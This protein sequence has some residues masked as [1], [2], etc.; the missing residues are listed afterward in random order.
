MKKNKRATRHKSKPTEVAVETVREEYKRWH[1]LAA[2]G[3]A[4]FA[5][6]QAYLPAINGA[7]V[8]DDRYL[9]FMHLPQHDAPLR[10]WIAGTRPTL[11]FSFWLNYKINGVV[12]YWYHVTNVLLH[13]ATGLLVFLIARKFLEW[14]GV[15]RWRKE[16]IAAFAAGLFL[17]HPLQTES[18]SYVASRS[19]NLSAL[20]FCGAFA[21]FLYRKRTAISFPRTLLVLILFGAAVTTKEH[22]AVLPVLLLLT[23]YYWNP[24]FSF[25]GIRRNWRLYLPLAV[26]AAAGSVFVWRTLIASDT[27]GFAV[28]GLPWYEYFY[29]QCRV[30][31][32][33]IRM[34]VLPFG[35]NI[36][37][38]YPISKS[39][40]EPGSLAGLI[41]LAALAGA[42]LWFRKRYK[43]ISFGILVFLLLLAPTSSF[44][45]IKDALAERRMYLP[46]IGPLLVLCD[47]AVRWKTSRKA[48]AGAMAAVLVVMGLLTYTRNL[49]WA[50]PI[51]LW[52]DSVAKSPANWRA[53]FQLAHAY[54]ENRRCLDSVKQ[55]EQAAALDSSDPRLF[56]NW[57]QASDCAG[58]PDEALAILN[59]ALA[60]ER[61][62]HVYSVIGMIKAK[63]GKRD[64]A[65]EALATAEKLD[66][67]FAPLYMFRGNLYSL[68]GDNE[69][70]AADYRRALALDRSLETA[71]RALALVERRMKQAQ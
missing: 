52:E 56:V 43:L 41:G 3:L 45:P 42:A 33:Y 47:L 9:P 48:L 1:L 50:G 17:L 34:F 49:V 66:P 20:L 30:I 15:D 13:V 69:K 16:A 6:F 2:A 25:R 58:K 61:S 5:V 65:F 32:V 31:W 40:L 27:A 14:Q 57:A 62:A 37:H 19:E 36:D 8:F 55:Y 67:N 38:M 46:M 63:Q 24:G 10:G 29:T 28:P 64:E 35:Q 22:T 53:R 18:V 44:V 21:L 70:A 12:P 68:D 39:L 26:G 71:R 23:D 59:R 4:A 7:F 60:M 51:E 54:Y 11:M